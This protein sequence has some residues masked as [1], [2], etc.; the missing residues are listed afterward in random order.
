MVVAKEGGVTW[1]HGGC[2]PISSLRSPSYFSGTADLPE[3][4]P[5]HVSAHGSPHD[6]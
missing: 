5:I 2:P 1:P 4:F 3:R 6:L